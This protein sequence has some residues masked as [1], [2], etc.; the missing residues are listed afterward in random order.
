[1][2]CEVCLNAFPSAGPI[3]WTAPEDANYSTS[4]NYFETQFVPHHST[5]LSLKES[6]DSG[7]LICAT[8]WNFQAAP[9]IAKQLELEASLSNTEPLDLDLIRPGTQLGILIVI[10]FHPGL[11]DGS[12]YTIQQAIRVDGYSK[13]MLQEFSLGISLLLKPKGVHFNPHC[14]FL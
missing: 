2:L 8:F 1:M 9:A 12:R 3:P 10:R 14:S 13:D 5:L 11:A 7:C 6:V 4:G